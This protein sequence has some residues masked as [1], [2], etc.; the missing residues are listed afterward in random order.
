MEADAKAETTETHIQVGQRCTPTTAEQAE[1][2]GDHILIFTPYV[3]TRDYPT[4]TGG[5]S[6]APRRLPLIILQLDWPDCASGFFGH[7]SGFLGPTT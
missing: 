2:D 5:L 7:A 3:L 1:Q 4:Y 6:L